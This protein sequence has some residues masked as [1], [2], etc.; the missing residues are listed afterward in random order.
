MQQQRRNFG[1][2]PAVTGL[3]EQRANVCLSGH[4]RP[5]RMQAA[6]SRAGRTRPRRGWWQ[7]PG[8]RKQ[9]DK[10]S[11]E[12]AEARAEREARQRGAA[13]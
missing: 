7:F 4:S 6:K 10:E 9:Q 3:G 2:V 13:R 8:A 12:A 1:C 11:R 5:G